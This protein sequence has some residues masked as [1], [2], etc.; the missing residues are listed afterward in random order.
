MP[1]EPLRRPLAHAE[2]RD[3]KSIRYC[4]AEW[5]AITLAAHARGIEPSAFARDLSLMAL[6]VET[7]AL[8]EAHLK[9]LSVLRPSG[10]SIPA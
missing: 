10:Q 9:T 3:P 5:D 8:M 7:P 2:S 4:P 1:L 6:M